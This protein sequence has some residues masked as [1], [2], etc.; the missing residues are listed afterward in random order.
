MKLSKLAF[1]AAIAWGIYASNASAQTYGQPNQVRQVAATNDYFYQPEAS[2]SDRPPPAPMVE[3][4]PMAVAPAAPAACEEAEEETCDPWRL[5]CQKECGWNITGFVNAGV[6]Y[7]FNNPV[8]PFNGPVTFGDRNDGQFNALYIVGEKAIDRETCCWNWGGRV[9]VLYGSDYIFTQSNGWETTPAG[10][11]KWNGNPNHGLAIPQLYAEVGNE[12]NSI[13]L[14]HFY[15]VLGYEVVPANGNFFYS[16][17]YTMQY[18]EPFTHWGM[19]GSYKY[20]D[21]VSL[22]YGIVNGWDALTRV[23]DDPAFIAGFTWTG[24]EDVLAFNV[25][26]GNEPTVNGTITDRYTHSL[27][28]T[29][30]IS[31]EWQYIFQHDYGHQV[32]GQIGGGGSAEWYG[33]NQYLFYTINDCWKW[34]F[35]GEWF[36]DDDGVR[37]TGVR[38]NNPLVGSGFA[39]NFY[40]LTT[41]LNYSPTANLT[42]RGEVRYDWF[43]GASVAGLPLPYADGTRTDQTTLGLDF[44]YLF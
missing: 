29:R 38:P 25:I 28:Y 21:E 1:A 23:Q 41:G 24:C 31:E 5:F 10:A 34:G 40:E 15:T 22:N 13:K 36:R 30:N 20:S 3:Q 7:N 16:H 4:A 32:G 11:P 33:I 35:R 19:L 17:A 8:T 43:D 44:I 6:N 39:G 12:N 26:Y 18:G 42:I 27:V 14:G 9:D 37:V 2:P